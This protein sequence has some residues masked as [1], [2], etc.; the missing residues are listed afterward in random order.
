[1]KKLTVT[2]LLIMIS[3]VLLWGEY[4]G[5]GAFLK[6]NGIAE[7]ESGNYYVFHGINGTYTG[8]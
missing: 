6:I 3:T 7:L 2:L 5:T 4:T 1:M 8:L